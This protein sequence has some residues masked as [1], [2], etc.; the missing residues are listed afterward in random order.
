MPHMRGKWMVLGVPLALA[1]GCGSSG[2]GTAAATASPTFTPPTIDGT[3]ALKSSATG[4]TPDGA[5]FGTGG[6]SDIVSGAQ[7]TLT[8][9]SGTI[10]GTAVLKPG[11]LKSVNEC[12]LAFSFGPIPATAKFYSAQVA[13]RGKITDSSS[14]LRGVDWHFSLTL[15]DGS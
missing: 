12:D 2:K 1:V 9:E 7:V 11:T 14:E 4:V 13:N 6:Y 8:N 15:G 5:C 3:L 10:L